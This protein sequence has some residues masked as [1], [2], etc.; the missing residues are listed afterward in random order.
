MKRGSKEEEAWRNVIKLGLKLG[1]REDIQRRKELAT[2][3][4]NDNEQIWKKTRLKIYE[5]LAQNFLIGQFRD[6]GNVYISSDRARRGFS[7][8]QLLKQKYDVT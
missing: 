1:D 3:A 6:P 7:F 4:M 2:I 5:T 8:G